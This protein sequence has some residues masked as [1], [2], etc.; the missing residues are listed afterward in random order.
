MFSAKCLKKLNC[1]QTYGRRSSWCRNLS[2]KC[3]VGTP[4]HF[5]LFFGLPFRL[6]VGKRLLYTGPKVAAV[7]IMR[8]RHPGG[9]ETSA[10]L[11]WLLCCR[12]K[13]RTKGC[14]VRFEPLLSF[15]TLN[16]C[17]CY[18]LQQ[19]RLWGDVIWKGAIRRG[20]KPRFNREHL[21]D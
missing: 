4:L 12:R 21:S 18:A 15:S 1:L 11:A 9:V 8:S 5:S 16:V 6:R 3:S 2:S 7:E 17:F 20:N 19:Q 10:T 14:L 13:S